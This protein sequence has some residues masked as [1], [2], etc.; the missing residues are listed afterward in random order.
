[1]SYD[2]EVFFNQFRL[3]KWFV[4]HLTSYR[5][6]HKAYNERQM[7]NHFWAMTIDAHLLL[8][9]IYWCMVFGAYSNPTH[10]TKLARTK[11]ERQ[12]FRTELYQSLRMSKAEY[13]KYWQDMTDFRNKYAAHRDG[14]TD[15]VPNF[16][17]ALKVAFFYYDW[18]QTVIVPDTLAEP[19][20]DSFD[21][22]LQETMAPFVDKLMDCGATINHEL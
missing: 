17:T 19:P 5:V 20:F 11:L 10:W 4:Y 22:S 16:D 15:P 12:K 14:F 2:R 9:S 18:V 7:V 3:V 13:G 1:M 21:K 8:A 6:L